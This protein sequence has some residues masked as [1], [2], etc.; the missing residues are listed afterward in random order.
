MVCWGITLL[1]YIIKARP[2]AHLV[3]VHHGEAA[4][5][6]LLD[7]AP[8]ARLGALAGLPGAVTCETRNGRTRGVRLTL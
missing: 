4:A 5:D 8:A 3:H 2:N 7:A 1:I 6:V